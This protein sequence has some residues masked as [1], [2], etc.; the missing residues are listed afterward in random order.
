MVAVHTNDCDDILAGVAS[1][2]FTCSA[3]TNSNK[4]ANYRIMQI[5]RGGKV[6]RLHDLVVIRRKTFTIV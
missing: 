6:S 5:V 2:K 3:F 1:S 4:V